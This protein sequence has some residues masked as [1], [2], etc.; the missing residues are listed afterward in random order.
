MRGTR[1]TLRTIRPIAA[2]LML[3]AAAAGPALGD[4][5]QWK[6]TNTTGTD[7]QDLHL[8]WKKGVPTWPGGAPT[9][10][11]ANTFPGASGSGT[12]NTNFRKAF[13]GTGVANNGSVV[14]TFEFTGTKPVLEKAWWTFNNSLE[15]LGDDAKPL[16]VVDPKKNEWVM[17]PATGDGLLAVT[18]DGTRSF[19]ETTA[20]DTGQAT[21]ARFAQFIGAMP[22]GDVMEFANNQVTYNGLSYGDR[23]DNLV[24]DVLRQDSTQP[25]AVSVVPEPTALAALAMAP[26][27]SRRRRLS[28]S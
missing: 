1:G 18:I 8:K 13:T 28:T 26:L 25:V 16:K 22:Y 2:A 20:G 10:D 5:D 17:A 6:F 27:L 19:F 21:A 24:V 11:P 15:T 9:Q 3:V 12:A 4:Q 14:M 23:V 7:A